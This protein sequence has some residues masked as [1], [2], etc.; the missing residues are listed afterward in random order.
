LWYSANSYEQYRDPKSLRVFAVGT[1]LEP[2]AIEWLKDVGWE[3]FYNPG[4]Q[5]ASMEHVIPVKG[6]EIH[7]HLDAIIS[8]PNIGHILIDIKTMNDRSYTNWRRQGTEEKSPQYLDQIH[9]YADAAITA[10]LS[11]DQLGIVGIN[12]NNSDMHIE[13]M[14]YSIERMM[15]IRARA[16]RIFAAPSAPE[17]GGR[18]ANWACNYCGYRN[19]CDIQIEKQDTTVGDGI[20][21]TTDTDIVNAIEMLRESRDL[22]KTAKDLS[23]QAKAVLDEKVKKAGIQSV[24]GGSFI[25]TLSEIASS[26]FDSATF[27][28]AHPDLAQ[29]YT[30]E[31][32]SVRYDVKEAS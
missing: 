9:V 6:G 29:Q 8:K 26:R 13:I 14:D 23:D 27:K 2:V 17:P 28:K 3:V 22:E 12:K 19:V 25:L 11:V 7:G 16:E 21:V 10:G 32:K 15:E 1:A 30:K 31:S 18:L 20:S 24:R 4:S 5:N